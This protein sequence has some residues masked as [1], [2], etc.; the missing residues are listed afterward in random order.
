MAARILYLMAFGGLLFAGAAR[1]EIDPNLVGWWNFEE[2]Q[3]AVALDS[4]GH[5]HH[6]TLMGDPQWVPG[7][8]GLALDLDGQSDYIETHK[9]PSELG[10]GGRAPRT[11]ALWV[12]T[13]RFNG[14]GVYEMGGHVS[15]GDGFCLRTHTGDNEW[16]LVYG[17]WEFEFTADSLD[18]WVHIT[19]ANDSYYAEVYVNGEQ[20]MDT[21][22]R[23]DTPDELTFRI[24][25]CEDVAFD[26]LIDDVRL[27]DRAIEKDEI[28]RIMGGDPSR[29]W[30]PCPAYGSHPTPDLAHSLRWSAGAGAVEHDIYL[31]T[32]RAAVRDATIDTE[33]IYR[34]RQPRG[35]TAYLLPEPAPEW[36]T[37]YYWR[38]D[39]VDADGAISRGGLWRFT[40]ADSL[41]GWWKLDEGEGNVAV[42]SSGHGN[43][44]TLMGDPRWVPGYDGLALDFDGQGDY[45]ETGKFPSEL[46]VDGN[47]PRTVALW[48]YTRSFNGGGLYEM[49]GDGNEEGFSLQTRTGDNEWR[50][51][52]GNYGANFSADSLNEWVHFTHVHDDRYTVLYAN[53]ERVAR[54]WP[55]LETADDTTFRIGVT[56]QVSFD[57]LIDDVRLYSRVVRQDQV[58]QVMQGD[59]RR[60][61][62]P[63][64]GHGSMPTLD[65]VGELR[66]SAG[67]DAVAH[68]VY[69]GTDSATVSEATTETDGI[70][71]GRQ[72]LE[73]AAYVPPA[74]PLEWNATY[75]WRI[76][77][78][79][80]DGL[81]TKGALWHFSTLDYL[82]I[83]DFE[84]YDDID[85]RIYE[86]WIDGWDNG[87]GS[88]VGYFETGWLPPIVHEGQQAMPFTYDNTISPW[89]SEAF[90]IW[91]D[92]Q[93][94]TRFG[95]D[96]LTLFL[97]G[98]DYGSNDPDQVYVALA[99]EAGHL[100]VVNHPDPLVVQ[101]AVWE[102]WDIPLGQFT[103]AGVDVT[104][105]TQMFT[106]V[107]DRDNPTPVGEGMVH[108]DDFRLT[109]SDMAAEPNTVPEADPAANPDFP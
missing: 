38:V 97:V 41:A 39:E 16:R 88:I 69:F 27:Y 44:G 15:A 3:G 5:D 4:S 94:W 32:D 99:D 79:S 1:A 54:A 93:D 105:V 31:G 29:A 2:G 107:G 9:L 73:A 42:D 50:L 102:R 101:T 12:H 46:G 28:A 57:G 100:K 51:E 40:A 85:D 83:D 92:P 35:A 64:P 13:R 75:Y 11:V 45:I 106:G 20:I 89:Y 58:S 59:P 24:G 84:S 26:G 55:W 48:A 18:E 7:Y 104:K 23:L 21:W 90:R 52:Y 91:E 25:V 56:G 71:H 86:T 6:G 76:D 30:G 10:M 43:H 22:R 8:D 47:V 66:W 82:I 103:A 77:E 60:A 95:V 67:A 63:Q 17:T 70:Y 78:I 108:F 62:A 72:S 68:D 81:A 33:D 65:G 61:W 80:S 49:G 19:H 53:A 34:G 14:G 87:T 109:R 74:A 37:T 96:T 36:D 98:L